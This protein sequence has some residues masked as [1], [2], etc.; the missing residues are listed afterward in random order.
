MREECRY[1][2][3]LDTIKGCKL[4]DGLCMFPADVTRCPVVARGLREC[5]DL[6]RVLPLHSLRKLAMEDQHGSGI[7]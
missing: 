2:Y 4:N 1:Q 7:S 6:L 5:S 3:T